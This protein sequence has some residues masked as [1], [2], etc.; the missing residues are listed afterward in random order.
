MCAEKNERGHEHVCCGRHNRNGK[1]KGGV[2]K[3]D[4]EFGRIG[5]FGIDGRIYGYMRDVQP[6]WCVDGWTM[7][8]RIADR[9]IIARAAEVK[10]GLLVLDFDT[11]V[12]R[13]G[14]YACAAC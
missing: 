12:F 7:Y 5:A 2:I 10:N 11:P 9:R 1:L 4:S 8:S 13:V 3:Y 6:L 14:R